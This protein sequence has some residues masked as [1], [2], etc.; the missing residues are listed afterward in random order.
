MDEH[1]A[2]AVNESINAVGNMT[3]DALKMLE[4]WACNPGQE[5]VRVLAEILTHNA[6]TEYVCGLGLGRSC[7]DLQTFKR[8]TPV[9]IYDNIKPL[10]KRIVD[11]DWSPIL[12]AHPISLLFLSS[13][14]S[15]GE[16]KFIPTH[17]DDT[18]RRNDARKLVRTLLARALQ[19]V[20]HVE[21]NARRMLNFLFVK[22]E[23]RTPGGL[24]VRTLIT[25]FC[26]SEVFC[27][28]T[29]STYT[30]PVE[31]F[32]CEDVVQSMYCQLLCGLIRRSEVGCVGAVYASGLL[33]VMHFLEEWW[34]EL[35][36]D[37]RGGTLS[38]DKVWDPTVR[39]SVEA[40][41]ATLGGPNPV[42]A[43][44]VE[45]ECKRHPKWQG[46]ICRLWPQAKSVCAIVTGSM[47]Q[48]VSLLEF[49]TGGDLP[50]V[51]L[52]YASSE[53][54]FGVNLAPLCPV[55][56]I[57][58]FLLP[59]MA[60]FEFL[61]CPA[62]HGNRSMHSTIQHDRQAQ[63]ASEAVSSS[64]IDLV[65][66]KLGED[67]ELVV[68]TY[69][70]LYRYRMGDVLRVTG[71]YKKAPLFQFVRRANVL[72]SIDAEETDE[73]ILQRAVEVATSAHLEATGWRLVDYTSYGDISTTPGHYVL[74]W[75]VSRD[76]K[77]WVPSE[78]IAVRLDATT[79]EACCL[80]MEENLGSTY[81]LSRVLEKSIGPLE[82]RVV[83]DGTFDVIMEF[84]C[85][86]QGPIKGSSFSQYKTPRCINKQHHAP[87]LDLLNSRVSLSSFGPQHPSFASLPQK[88]IC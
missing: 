28:D 84:L 83:Q 22:P 78:D 54:Y 32:H 10:M 3:A 79:L 9:I 20:G 30:S 86:Q 1:E 71:F 56:N 62:I 34:Q 14:T 52:T 85:D 46:I 5:Q 81:K 11:G 42:V 39:R 59:N 49:Y 76:R 44:E 48:Y 2:T 57:S 65:D 63:S 38:S 29:A 45:A 73:E 67:Y 15:S 88:I 75:E 24:P 60:Y 35:V 6:G 4:T 74:F 25:S 87:I 7:V 8:V 51:S 82:I 17:D 50:L 21:D 80:A 36:K 18:Q 12:T 37:I 43:E 23:F 68:T 26:R 41:I 13:A 69:T 31:V 66:V 16:P 77:M 19:E 58:Y 70:G 27:A 53:C 33:R 64:L 61:P 40:L 72:L 55:S 47:S